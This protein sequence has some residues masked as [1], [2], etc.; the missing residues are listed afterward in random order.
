MSGKVS[1]K[2]VTDG[3]VLN[4][5]GANPKSYVSGSTTWDDLTYYRNN[6]TLINSPTFD[7][8]NNGSIVFDGVDDYC[9][10][11]YD[12]SRIPYGTQSI[13]VNAWFLPKR[14]FSNGEEIIGIGSNSYSGARVGIWLADNLY[15]EGANC[16]VYEASLF[17]Y[18]EEWI[19]VSFI[20]PDGPSNFSDIK[21][22]VN[23]YQVLTDVLNDTLINIDPQEILIGVIPSTG[24]QGPFKG[25]ISTIQIYNRE[26]T[27]SEV[28]QNYNALKNRFI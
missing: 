24:V 10:I 22:Y 28:L 12:T 14:G 4:L 2:I 9:S 1:S 25:N 11:Y 17:N 27:P 7:S 20:V 6:G 15:I 18:N 5:D 19:N 16:G 23:G 3:L 21:L 8:N 26:L 13:S